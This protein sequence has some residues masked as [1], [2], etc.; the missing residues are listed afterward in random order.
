MAA[1]FS[2]SVEAFA[3]AADRRRAIPWYLWFCVLAVTSAIVGIIWDISWHRSIGRDT[4]W[5]PAHM[6]IYLCGVLAGVTSGYLILS[7]TFDRNSPLRESAVTMWGFRGPLGAFIAAWGGIAMLVSA[8]FDNWWHNAYGLDVK[9]ISPPH[10]LLFLGNAAIQMGALILI[11]GQMNRAEAALQRKFD[12]LFIYA[13]GMLTLLVS[14]FI[15]TFSFPN[16]MHSAM[17]YRVAA[18]AFPFALIGIGGASHQRWGSTKI[19]AIYMAVTLASIWI[20]PLFPAE[21][22]LGPVYHQVKEFIPPPFPLLL[23]VPALLLDLLREK[24]AGRD[25]WLQSAV[26]GLLFIGS[27]MAVEWPFAT[28]LLSP[29]ARN[30]AFGIIYM[31]Y[32]TPPAGAIANFR[33]FDIDKGNFWTNLIVGV[34][35]AILTVRMGMAWADS[36]RRVRR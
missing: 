24:M 11:L 20:L 13:G 30:R 32:G 23:I 29:A 12:W 28:F 35:L 4:F 31:D 9:I 15:M 33:F 26:A 8:P 5:T 2:R 19:A 16:Q 3:S 27:L 6:A 1:T 10:T 22:K 25:R 17:A 36:M 34:F 7:T 18:T 14:I 21:P